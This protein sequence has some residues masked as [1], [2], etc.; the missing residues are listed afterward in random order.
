L[1]DNI[2]AAW[3]S[4]FLWTA[5]SRLWLAVTLTLAANDCWCKELS[6]ENFVFFKQLK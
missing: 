4:Y 3:F 6:K 1:A 5:V 2:G